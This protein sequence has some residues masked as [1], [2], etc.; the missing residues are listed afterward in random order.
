MNFD[1]REVSDTAGRE[2]HEKEVIQNAN[3][4]NTNC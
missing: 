2:A 3:A 4:A 1:D